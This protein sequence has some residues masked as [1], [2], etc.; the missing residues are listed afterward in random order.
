MI[1]AISLPHSTESS[2][3][4][5]TSPFFRLW[6]VTR[7]SLSLGIW[8]MTVLC[9]PRRGLSAGELGSGRGALAVG[10]VA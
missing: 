2:V 4:F 7:L 5:F 6:K 9:L 1:S 3:A 10:I 8:L